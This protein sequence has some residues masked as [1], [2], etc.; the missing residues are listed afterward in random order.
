MGEPARVL[1]VVELAQGV[2]GPVAG[3][4]FAGLGHEVV[5]CEP[6]TGD[7]LRGTRDT[8]GSGPDVMAFGFAALNAGKQSVAIDLDTAEGRHSAMALIATA[9]VVISDLHADQAAALSLMGEARRERWPELVTMSVT[10]FGLDNPWSV[11]RPDSMLAESFGGLAVMIGEPNRR[12]LSLGGEQAAYAA[13]F[14][15]FFGAMLALE[16]VRQGH[17]GDVAD[18]A[19]SDVAAYIDWKS[20][21]AHAVTGV[22]PRRGGVRRGRWRMVPALDGWAGVIYQP[23]QW[24]SMIELV[25]DPR[26]ADP[27]FADEPSRDESVEEWWPVI[28]EWAAVRTRDQIYKEAQGLG[29]AFGISTDMADLTASA[30]YRARGFI[31][32]PQPGIPSPTLGKFFTSAELPWRTGDVPALG[33]HTAQLLGTRATPHTQAASR[34]AADAADPT[35]GPLD[36]MV[37]LDLGTITAGAAT[38]RLL[39]DY[40][41][42][43]IKVE[44]KE[45]PDPFRKWVIAGT[46]AE[47]LPQEGDTVSPVFESNNAGKLGVTLD[48]KSDE[49]REEFRRLVAGADV[50]IE[51]FRVGVTKRLGV[52]Y[53]SLRKVNP[54]LIYLSLSSQGQDGPEAL[55]RSYGSTLDML[56]GLASLT[57]YED[58]PPTWS[59]V[60][61]NY[62]DQL[63]SL[64]GAALVA[65]C[66]NRRVSTYVDV[67]QRETVSWTLSDQIEAF[68]ATGRIAGPTG[69]R[70]P[71]AAPH[72]V[73]PCSGVDRWV[74]IACFTDEQRAALAAVVGL[75]RIG[76]DWRGNGDD[77]RRIDQAIAAWT[78]ARS[79]DEC[80]RILGAITVP[81][82]P[83][84]NAE[85]RARDTHFIRHRVFLDGPVRRKGFPLVFEGHLPPAPR[86]APQVGEHTDLVLGEGSPI[87]RS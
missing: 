42:T 32:E 6:P 61:V 26:L 56:S 82:V 45:R 87:R 52:D 44:A 1:R 43:V 74:A 22:T 41:A 50:V 15:G 81:C 83:V 86:P 20:D 19:L 18:V 13:G 73:Y 7:Y 71:G 46:P 62:P 38:G 37:V 70:R 40:G 48:L 2:A 5:K 24:E 51:N 10:G 63:V 17:S 4:L 57:G 28:E 16:R 85:D 65:Y 3:R 33:Q 25:G 72:D 67:A 11:H 78:G 58:G 39:A 21:I 60:D 47:K 23:D 34:A 69:N 54:D 9:D 68:L 35:A 31:P 84:L 12:P 36:G 77:A 53:A 8:S 49:G 76:A 59:S 66:W 75:D 29:L 30:H 27:R 55:S 80:V 14:V 79:R 64:F